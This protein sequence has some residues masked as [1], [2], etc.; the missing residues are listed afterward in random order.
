VIREARSLSQSVSRIDSNVDADPST[1][2][3]EI[4]RR[5]RLLYRRNNGNVLLPLILLLFYKSKPMTEFL[6]YE[7]IVIKHC[8]NC[9]G[10]ETIARNR[11]R[12]QIQN[13]TVGKIQ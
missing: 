1:F 7:E 6:R 4:R 12:I 2:A 3:H 9:D 13:C 5:L 11:T 10:E 8:A